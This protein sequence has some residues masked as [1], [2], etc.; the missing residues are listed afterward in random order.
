M[1][2]HSF[3]I[4]LPQDVEKSMRYALYVLKIYNGPIFSE[5][6]NIVKDILKDGELSEE[7]YHKLIKCTKKND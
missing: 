2:D 7:N 6:K 3:P 5:F 4:P 1:T